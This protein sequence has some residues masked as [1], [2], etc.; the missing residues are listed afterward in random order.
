M[1]L[2]VQATVNRAAPSDSRE[3]SSCTE[4]RAPSASYGIHRRLAVIKTDSWLRRLGLYGS[5]CL[6][7]NDGACQK[8]KIVIGYKFLMWLSSTSVDL[9]AEV[10]SLSSQGF[11]L[12]IL[13]GDIRIQRR[14]HHDSPFILA[15]INGDVHSI[16]QHLKERTGSV[17][18]RTICTGMTPLMVLIR[19]LKQIINLLMN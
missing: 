14:I 4:L 3:R 6:A 12:R 5:F 2:E 17:R 1:M 11:G 10:A 18:D 7:S 16:E 8:V 9:V 19:L 13:P 15:C